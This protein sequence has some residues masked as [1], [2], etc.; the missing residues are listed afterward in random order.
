M[1]SL[2]RALIVL[3]F[4]PFAAC[5]DY[6][7]RYFGVVNP[8]PVVARRIVNTAGGLFFAD[9]TIVSIFGN[10]GCR[11]NMNTGDRRRNVQW[12]VT[13]NAG[14]VLFEQD[15]QNFQTTDLSPFS[16]VLNGQDFNVNA[17]SNGNFLNSPSC[18]FRGSTLKGHFASDFSGF[19]ATEDMIFGLAGSEVRVQ[20]HWIATRADQ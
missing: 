10:P 8:S 15:P 1:K 6:Q 18:I 11:L 4:I 12:R 13:P 2:L 3:S 9:S 20:K 14:A 19:D 5:D 17:T 16:G 7:F